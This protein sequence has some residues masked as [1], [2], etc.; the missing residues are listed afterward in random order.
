MCT[1]LAVVIPLHGASSHWVPA[2]GLSARFRALRYGDFHRAKVQSAL[3]HGG[4]LRT[5]AHESGRNAKSLLGN[6]FPDFCD[7]DW[8]SKKSCF[9]SVFCVFGSILKD[10]VEFC[11]VC[12]SFC[13]LH[14]FWI[15]SVRIR[16]EQ[17]GSQSRPAVNP[18][19]MLHHTM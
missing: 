9:F 13:V 8:F 3:W 2:R 10:S 6:D 7:F 19:R 11:S 5:G 18:G 12:F 4:S 17:L 16:R 15:D 14:S 1:Y